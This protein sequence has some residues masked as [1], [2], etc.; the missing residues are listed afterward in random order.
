M[1]DRLV[2]RS[3]LALLCLAALCAGCAGQPTQLDPRSAS[4]PA[5]A[6]QP[7]VPTQAR[8]AGGARTYLLPDHDVP[9]VRLFLAFRGGSLHDPPE[10][11]G[12]AQV[13]SLAWRTGG[14]EGLSPEALDEALE[15]KGMQLSV[16]LGRELGWIGLSVLPGDLGE[17]LDLLTRIVR[18]PAF[19]ENRV[20]WA[21]TQVSE[22]IQREVDDPQAL[23]FREL[24]RAL[25]R[26]HPRGVIPTAETVRNVQRGDIVAL[27]RRIL[28]ESAW[29][30][31]AV[32]DFD[33]AALAQE[34]EA[35][36]SDLP[37]SGPAF[38][39]LPPPQKP[40]ARVILVRR[41]LPQSTIVWAR[42][43]PAR[44][45]P[46]FYPLEVL[47]YAAGSGGFQSLLVRE[48]RS[49]L[50]LAYSV[51]TFYEAFPEFGVLGAHAQTK[52]ESTGQVLGLIRSLLQGVA[53]KG[54]DALELEEAKQA[55]VNRHIF[56]YQDPAATVQDQ[57]D[58]LLEGLPPDLATVYPVRIS[59]VSDREAASAAARYYAGGEGVT[60]VV[61]ELTPDDPTW[62]SGP[63]VD[64][65]ELR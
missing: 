43:G 52:T 61:G 38:G 26:G 24:K 60:V 42:L 59:G 45:A 11:A 65:V 31:G 16:S 10:K 56:R 53:E 14:T 19:S 13:T 17:G 32:G 12:L 21:L 9:L 18:A 36:F 5:P 27:H 2:S 33:A 7:P 58:L 54:L 28:K 62:K 64:V 55:L 46:E 15:G 57:M 6:F 41:P 35:R 30:L 23:A 49:N 4:F 39:A 29:V 47:D 3:V 25:Y 20:G 48:I 51:G 8:L 37:G 44:T 63:P 34:L 50:G 22:R 1:S 40:E